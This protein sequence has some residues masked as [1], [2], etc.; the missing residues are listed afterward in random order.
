MNA[1]KDRRPS[2]Q[3]RKALDNLKKETKTDQKKKENED[4]QDVSPGFE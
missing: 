2:N 4:Q 3:G 1:L